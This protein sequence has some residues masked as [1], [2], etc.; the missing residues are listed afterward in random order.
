MKHSL[1]VKAVDDMLDIE[2]QARALNLALAA[3]SKDILDF[4]EERDFE[5]L[6][7]LS[8]GMVRAIREHTELLN[9]IHD[10]ISNNAGTGDAARAKKRNN[11]LQRFLQFE[12][13][14]E[15][16]P[17]SKFERDADGDVMTVNTV[18][19]RRHINAPVRVQITEGAVKEEIV[20]LMSKIAA[21]IDREYPA[22][23]EEI[24]SMM[25]MVEKLQKQ[26]DLPDAV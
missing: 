1:L 20:V 12:G 13:W 17:D 2:S 26:A 10:Q 5:A 16:D 4:D 15:T 3:L 7:H 6:W 25:N 24:T 22:D 11:K 19:E 18:Y 9:V 14:K 21:W 8:S 23:R